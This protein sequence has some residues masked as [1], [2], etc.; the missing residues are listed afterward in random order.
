MDKIYTIN[1]DEQPPNK[2]GTQYLLIDIP[3]L[4]FNDVADITDDMEYELLQEIMTETQA[5]Y[6]HE[7]YPDFIRKILLGQTDEIDVKKIYNVSDKRFN[8]YVR[9][10]DKRYTSFILR[11]KFRGYQLT[12]QECSTLF[13]IYTTLERVEEM[14][15]LHP[16]MCLY[17][18]CHRP[19]RRTDNQI[20]S[21]NQDVKFSDERLEYMVDYAITQFENEGSTYVDAVRMAEYIRSIDV[22]VLEY[23]PNPR[24][25]SKRP[26]APPTA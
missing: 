4:S 11:G 20:M 12:P 8:T 2:Y 26:T 17:E 9:K 18:I 13:G 21:V 10:I 22:D 3:S 6:V 5:N 1:V 19:F 23:L 24:M 14:L 15:N 25:C 7:A 16:Y